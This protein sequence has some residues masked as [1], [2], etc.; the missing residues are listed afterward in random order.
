MVKPKTVRKPPPEPMLA[1]FYANFQC[2]FPTT[3][4]EKTSHANLGELGPMRS[5][6]TRMASSQIGRAKLLLGA[7]L[8]LSRKAWEPS[9]LA[10]FG[11]AGA[12]PSRLRFEQVSSAFSPPINKKIDRNA[13]FAVRVLENQIPS[14]Y[15]VI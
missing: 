10:S 14:V 11:S 15:N 7:K 3:H 6:T 5:V 2:E 4:I 8:P 13:R 1:T 12:S 9:V